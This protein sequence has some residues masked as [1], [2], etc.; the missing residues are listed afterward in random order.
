MAYREFFIDEDVLVAVSNVE[1][2]PVEWLD[3]WLLI[4]VCVWPLIKVKLEFEHIALNQRRQAY[5]TKDHHCEILLEEVAAD[6]II[7]KLDDVLNQVLDSSNLVIFQSVVN[8]CGVVEAH[9][10]L[11]R[12][13]VFEDDWVLSL[14]VVTVL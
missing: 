11:F 10:I 7:L 8:G 1:Q 6:K 13:P 5:T 3:T 9:S 12:N 2:G 4:W 14:E